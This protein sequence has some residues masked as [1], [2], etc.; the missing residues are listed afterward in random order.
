MVE[1]ILGLIVGGFAVI[2][3]LSGRIMF[4]SDKLE[5]ETIQNIKL[6][7][8]YRRLRKEVEDRHV[9]VTDL[10]TIYKDIYKES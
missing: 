10:D 3:A 7:H 9:Y 6:E 2:L 4:L 5:R 1:F 8:L